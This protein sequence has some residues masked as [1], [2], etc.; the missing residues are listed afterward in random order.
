MFADSTC[1]TL[2]ASRAALPNSPGYSCTAQE[3]RRTLDITPANMRPLHARL[4]L[5]HK[6]VPLVSTCQPPFLAIGESQLRRELNHRR[7]KTLINEPLRARVIEQL[8]LQHVVKK[9]HLFGIAQ[10]G[11]AKKSRREQFCASIAISVS[12]S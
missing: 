11:V 7:Q 1:S 10:N 12:C 8:C 4:L 2:G 9:K 5:F 3:I 6:S